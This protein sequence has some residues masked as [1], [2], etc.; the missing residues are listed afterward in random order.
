MQFRLSGLTKALASGIDLRLGGCAEAIRLGGRIASR[1]VG[2]RAGAGDCALGLFA[3]L[4]DRAV[5]VV[6]GA[7]GPFLGVDSRLRCL[8]LRLLCS[9]V[10]RRGCLGSRVGGGKLGAA[11]VLLAA[12]GVKLGVDTSGI[13]LAGAATRLVGT[14]AGGL[15]LGAK[16]AD[17]GAELAN[18]LAP[19]KGR[20]GAKLGECRSG[21]RDRIGGVRRNGSLCGRGCDCASL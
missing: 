9:G 5:G 2:K 13:G 1:L 12:A 19:G 18:G 14:V 17:L 15:E 21:R 16:V 20:L 4:R 7:L 10:D 8:V 3:R 6:A 11:Q